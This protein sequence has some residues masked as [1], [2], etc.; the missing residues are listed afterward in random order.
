[1]SRLMNAQPES[2][3][4]V[5]YRTMSPAEYQQVHRREDAVRT[6]S[7]HQPKGRTCK[8]GTTMPAG[9][10]AEHMANILYPSR[11]V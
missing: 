6:F 2:N 5:Q 8:C 10:W 7:E 11:V 3:T 1:M 9:G 4:S